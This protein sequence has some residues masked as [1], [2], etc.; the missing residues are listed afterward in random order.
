M[1]SVSWVTDQPA[2]ESPGRARTAGRPLGVVPWADR[3][4]QTLRD[5]QETSGQG[6]KE[7]LGRAGGRGGPSPCGS[8]QV[9]GWGPPHGEPGLAVTGQAGGRDLYGTG[10]WPGLDVAAVGDWERQIGELPKSPKPMASDTGLPGG[11]R[12][13]SS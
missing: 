2:G 1:R 12:A 11:R 3:R 5:M 9:L 10:E 13:G 8:R 6:R 7:S 4:P